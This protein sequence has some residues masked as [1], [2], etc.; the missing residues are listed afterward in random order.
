M[1]VKK[2]TSSKLSKEEPSHFHSELGLEKIR[3]QT[4]G[5][6]V[7]SVF[8]Q[9]AWLCVIA[10]ENGCWCGNTHDPLKSRNCMLQSLEQQPLASRRRSAQYPIGK[11][12]RSMWDVLLWMIL[13]DQLPTNPR[14]PRCKTSDGIVVLWSFECVVPML[15]GS[16][17][18]VL[19]GASTQRG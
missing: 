4:D 5:K 9:D 3:L 2:R 10:R 13:R 16:C 6:Y 8:F 17:Q 1:L 11:R 15:H 19:A 7:T 12:S 18:T 14:R